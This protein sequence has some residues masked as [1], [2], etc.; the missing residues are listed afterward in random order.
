VYC[1]CVLCA[2]HVTY[3]TYTCTGVWCTCVWCTCVCCTYHAYILCYIVH[4][5]YIIYRIYA[6]VRAVCDMR[7]CV[8]GEIIINILFYFI[9]FIILYILLCS[10]VHNIRKKKFNKLILLFTLHIWDMFIYI[11][12][13]LVF[14]Y[15]YYDYILYITDNN[16]KDWGLGDRHF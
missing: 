4:D 7:A 15:I 9:Y 11:Y 16:I 6:R 5:T 1:V 8:A 13:T 3:T 2:T 10:C 14:T 12:A